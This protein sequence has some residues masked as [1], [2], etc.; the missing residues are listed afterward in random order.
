MVTRTVLR[1]FGTTGSPNFPGRACVLTGNVTKP[2]DSAKPAQWRLKTTFWLDV[3]LMVSVCALQTVPFT[4]LVVHEW[5]GLAMV[6][7]VFAHLLL[8]W[9]WI[10]SLSRRLFAMQTLRARI[11]YLLNLTLFAAMTAVIFS[12]ILISQKAIPALT[13][14]KAPPDMDWRWDSLHNQF[15]AYVLMLSGFHLAINWEWAL[16]AGQKV[17]RRV[18]GGEV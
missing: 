13:G 9:S 6:A 10:A 17:F 15:S 4:G 8:S 7:M 11:N 5:L 14:T 1:R 12:G 18:L 3:T 2:R 16:A